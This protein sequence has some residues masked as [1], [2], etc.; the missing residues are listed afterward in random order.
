MIRDRF[1][2]VL[3]F[4]L[5]IIF[6]AGPAATM[7]WMNLTHANI[8]HLDGDT[9]RF[10]AAFEWGGDSYIDPTS[11]YEVDPVLDH[12]LMGNPMGE[13]IDWTYNHTGAMGYSDPGHWFGG[14]TPFSGTGGASGL[15]GP[16]FGWD[17]IYN[18]PAN[19]VF[20]MSYT[21]VM[22]WQEFDFLSNRAYGRAEEEFS[23]DFEVALYSAIPEPTT[24]IL[25]GFGLTGLG[26]ICRKR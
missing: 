1:T 18:G 16:E 13:P 6:L 23:A 12:L 3:A 8:Q 10:R 2:A 21:G 15:R 7:G 11:K 5:F 4:T 24:I 9:Y 22:A 14:Y 17:F 26:I 19:A 25:L 20:S